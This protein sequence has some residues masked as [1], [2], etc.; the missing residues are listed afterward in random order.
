MNPAP[1]MTTDELGEGGPN[2][3]RIFDGP[4]GVN[5]AMSSLLTIFSCSGPGS[6]YE[7]VIENFLVTHCDLMCHRV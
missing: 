4:E 3:W 2:G 1:T 7:P 5:A 6:D